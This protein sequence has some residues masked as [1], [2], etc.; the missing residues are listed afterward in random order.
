MRLPWDDVLEG[1][2]LTLDDVRERARRFPS[3]GR[4]DPGFVITEVERAAT[5]VPVVE[6]GG[7][8]AVVVTRRAHT[9]THHGGDW[10]FP[11]GRFDADHDRSTED[12]A[13]REAEEELGIAPGEVELLGRLDS[14]G[15]IL[16]GFVIDVYVGA[17]ADVGSVS[18]DP[19]EVAEVAVLQLSELALP[20]A[21]WFATT[22]PDGH[23]PGPLA[24]AP[25]ARR[26]V[27][28]RRHQQELRF[29]RVR[30]DEALWGTQGNIVWNLLE[31]LAAPR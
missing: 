24:D 11:G 7:E 13:R 16:T 4:Q 9:M 5:L 2:P 25:E 15:P 1:P 28:E 17:L 18:P 14:H 3:H 10:V 26:V 6:L 30:G 20:D 8:A 22:V 21:L 31:A 19:R 27:E 23:D 29:F 12:T